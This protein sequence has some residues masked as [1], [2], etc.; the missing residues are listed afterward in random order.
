MDVCDG[1]CWFWCATASVQLLVGADTLFSPALISVGN[2]CLLCSDA[3]PCILGLSWYVFN[4]VL[5]LTWPC[6]LGGR[7][8]RTKTRDL[9][10]FCGVC[11]P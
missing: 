10:L 11:K 8:S 3:E 2:S 5:L 9:C 6:L 7:A 4:L 1:L